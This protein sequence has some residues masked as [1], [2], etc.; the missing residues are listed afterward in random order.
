MRAAIPESG[1]A[2]LRAS[3]LAKETTCGVGAEAVPDVEAGCIQ[4]GRRGQDYRMTTATTTCQLAILQPLAHAGGPSPNK[5]R[6]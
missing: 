3:L 6:L 5:P 2:S 1:V 4:E